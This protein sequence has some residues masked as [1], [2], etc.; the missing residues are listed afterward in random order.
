M[1]M[2]GS[3]TGFG[4]IK[5]HFRQAIRLGDT[6]SNGRWRRQVGRELLAPPPWAPSFEH[7]LSVRAIRSQLRLLRLPAPASLAAGASAAA[8]ARSQII[9]QDE[10]TRNFVAEPDGAVDDQV[11]TR[12]P[13]LRCRAAARRAS[14]CG[15]V[16]ARAAAPHG[17]TD[18]P[19]GRLSSLRP[20]GCTL[21]TSRPT[22]RRPP[23]GAIFSTSATCASR[24]RCPR[25]SRR[26]RCCHELRRH[27]RGMAHDDA[28]AC[29]GTAAT[30]PRTAAA[31]DG[32]AAI[33]M[34]SCRHC[35]ACACALL[36]TAPAPAAR[37]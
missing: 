14:P 21:P 28:Y 35:P 6:I 15:S 29:V 7:A 37:C 2:C 36:S 33:C 30:G 10:S 9:L 26:C 8:S 3:N 31:R 25:C 19:L 4:A 20:T 32:G 5:C 34:L 27:A 24:P 23:R 11:R 12:V 16:P 17:S 13:H 22:C 18:C 1:Y